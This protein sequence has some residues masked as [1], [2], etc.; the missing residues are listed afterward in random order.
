MRMR[1][2]GGRQPDE[3]RT[4]GVGRSGGMAIA[5]GLI[6]A[7]SLGGSARAQSGREAVAVPDVASRGVVSAAPAPVAPNLGATGLHVVQPGESLPRIAMRYGLRP[8]D[9]ARLNGASVDSILL[10]GRR[11]WVPLSRAVDA[12]A[13]EPVVDRTPGAPRDSASSDSASKAS[14]SGEASEASE[15]ATTYTVRPGDT[16]YSLSVRFGVPLEVL[17][18]RNGLPA[19]GSLRVGETLFVSDPAEQP[20]RLAPSGGDSTRDVYLVQ[21]GDTLTSIAQRFGSSAVALQRENGL[22]GTEIRSGQ[23]LVV[24]RPGAG[25]AAAVRGPKRI[26]I[27][28]AEQRMYVWQGDTLIWNWVASTGIASHPTQ[29]GT[30]AVQSK[31]PNAWSNAWQLWMPN[32]LGIYWAGGSENGIHALPIINGRQL[33]AGSLGAPVSYGC[34]VLGVSEAELLYNWAEIGTP[35]VI[36]D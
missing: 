6:I 30:F 9:V 32:W 16:L 28:I 2:Q 8:I 27:S 14:G 31:I 1:M 21:P 15:A 19:D 5:L 34:V 25:P 36:R 26:E 11:L 17:K 29:R 12:R 7:L 35:V 23:T 18:R 33:W 10:P 4:A 13:H 3:L 20:E 22:F 24:P